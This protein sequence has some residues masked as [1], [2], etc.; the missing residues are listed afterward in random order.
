[1]ESQLTNIL[2]GVLSG[3][4]SA[5]ITY[6]STIKS[7]AAKVK[8]E[9]LKEQ[10]YKYFLPFKNYCIEFR[11]RVAHIEKI[12]ANKEPN[13]FCSLENNADA[14]NLEWYF[15]DWV[16]LETH[17]PGGYFI[18]TTVYMNCLLYSRIKI[19]QHEHPFIEVK[20][21]KNLKKILNEESG[22]NNK[23]YET[24]QKDNHHGSAGLLRTME[25]LPSQTDVK[26]LVE[27]IKTSTIT[28]YGGIPYSL[29]DS[30]GSFV[31]TEKGVIDYEQ[32][33]KMLI[34]K[35]QRV[36]F[37]PLIRFWSDLYLKNDAVDEKKLSKIGGLILALKLAENAE[38]R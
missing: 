3:A 1:M 20:L 23:Y 30:F 4:A 17:K 2:I 5:V 13:P 25:S 12:I 7:D 31:S 10:K 16:D 34:D 18:A 21:I 15:T 9:I 14:E 27:C 22:Q 24:L 32:F 28:R 26:K 11:H 37:M 29:Q 19:M 36:K 38:L 35:E 33:C 6:L 8:Q